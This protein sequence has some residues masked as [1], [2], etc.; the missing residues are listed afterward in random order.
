MALK[1]PKRPKFKKLPKQPKMTASIE[2]WKSYEN[3]LTQ[4]EKENDKKISVYKEKLK[5]YQ[6]AISARAR[7]KE[8]AAKIKQKSFKLAS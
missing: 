1:R 3:R 4:V 6:A 2:S 7:I 5:Q 8:K